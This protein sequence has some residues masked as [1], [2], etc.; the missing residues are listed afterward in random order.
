MIF[1]ESVG[2]G[3]SLSA[4]EQKPNPLLK[5]RGFFVEQGAVSL[6]TKPLC[7]A[8]KSSFGKKMLA[9]VRF[10]RPP[11]ASGRER[12]QRSASARSSQFLKK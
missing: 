3:A 10:A 5:G 4:K 8:K 6:L 1:S 12:R 9:F 2:S 7:C 11:A